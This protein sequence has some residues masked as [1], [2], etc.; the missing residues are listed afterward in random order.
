MKEVCERHGALLILDEIMSGMGRS[1][2][3]HEWQQEDV[4]P[5]L[6]TIGKGLAGGY[7]PV[8]GVLINNRVV[9]ALDK[10]TGAFMHGHT[11]QGHPVGC[12]TAYEVQ[13]VI[14]EERLVENVAKQGTLMESLLKK[15]LDGHPHVGD[16]RG[17]G[18]F[19]GVSK[20]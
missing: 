5:D 17:K 6:Q 11:Y 19:W 2:T 16:I 1:G 20:N 4:V 13:R 3:L 10:G 18:L 7:S 9:D 15:R 12:V 8:A 14:R